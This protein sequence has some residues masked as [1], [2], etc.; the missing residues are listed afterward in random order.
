[1]K[2]GFQGIECRNNATLSAERHNL[3]VTLNA[4]DKLFDVSPNE[5]IFDGLFYTPSRFPDSGVDIAFQ[6]SLLPEERRGIGD[7]LDFEFNGM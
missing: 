3:S 7:T 1:M 2:A 4:F 5:V 6:S